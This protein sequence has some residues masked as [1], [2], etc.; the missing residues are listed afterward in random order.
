MTKQVK[1]ISLK[2]EIIGK[3]TTLSKQE[4]RS[5]SATV[6]N[7]LTDVG[8]MNTIA[9]E[10]RREFPEVPCIYMAIDTDNI[11]QYIGKTVNLNQRWQAHHRYKQLEELGNVKIT[12]I[13]LKE[14][15]DLDIIEEEL[16]ELLNPVLNNSEI[17]GKSTKKVQT[18]I[19]EE[20]KDQF[21]E[22]C[23][24]EG[25]TMSSAIKVFVYK[26]IKENKLYN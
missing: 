25:H 20:I 14:T 23:E 19:P 7:I 21:K 16:I 3:I 9:L 2:P 22:V 13:K 24:K 18:F 15:L 4:R 10:E 5:F 8:T 17:A 11:I 1:S 6:E 12:Y 26:T